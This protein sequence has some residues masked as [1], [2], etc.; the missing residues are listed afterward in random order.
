MLES[1]TT[2]RWLRAGRRLFVRRILTRAFVGRVAAWLLCLA[3]VMAP[4][5]F[6]VD[7]ALMWRARAGTADALVIGAVAAALAC[8]FAL[9]LVGPLVAVVELV[10]ALGELPT[11]A[12]RLWPLPLA[13]ASL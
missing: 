13:A 2:I 8:L 5:A 6:V 9:V 12:R 7:A 10:E 4:L 11:G 1:W 3:A